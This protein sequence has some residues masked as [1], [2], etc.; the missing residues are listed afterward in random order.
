M[1]LVHINHLDL[2]QLF[3]LFSALYGVSGTIVLFLGSFAYEP[4]PMGLQNSKTVFEDLRKLSDRN[5]IR[6]FQQRVGLALL[7]LSFVF[8]ALSAF[9]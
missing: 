6:K 8:E 9:K 5:R 7:L 2:G 1:V 4:T 3:T